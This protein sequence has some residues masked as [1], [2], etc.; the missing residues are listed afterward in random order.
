VFNI[1]IKLPGGRA[2]KKASLKEL[3]ELTET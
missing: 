1:F 3:D 2:A